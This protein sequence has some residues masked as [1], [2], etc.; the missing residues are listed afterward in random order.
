MKNAVLLSLVLTSTLAFASPEAAVKETVQTMLNI[1]KSGN[2]RA[3]VTALCSLVRQRVDLVVLGTD[4]LGGYY[5]RLPSDAQGIAKFK[6]LVPSIIMDS[7]YDLL[8]GK[9]N[10]TY[11]YVGTAA[12]GSARVGVRIKINGT[13]FTVTVIKANEKVVDV[14]YGGYSLVATK[15]GELQRELHRYKSQNLSQPCFLANS[16]N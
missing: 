16:T 2:D 14:E 1:L 13:P 9:G 10:A 3:Q 6:A 7:F 12:K 5:G 8:S 11:E 15:R 4:L